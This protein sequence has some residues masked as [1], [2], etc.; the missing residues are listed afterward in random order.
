MTAEPL[1]S[2]RMGEM[3]VASGQAVLRALLG[4][5][6]GLALYDSS[7]Q[8][9]GL[10]HI[11]LPHSR[12]KTDL[13]AKFVDTAIPAMVR[14]MERVAGGPLRLQ[15]KMAGG[16]NMFA[17]RVANTIG[18]QNIEM[19]EQ[20]LKELRIPIIARHVGGEKGRNMRLES[21]TGRVFVEVVGAEMIEL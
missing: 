13:P 18:K 19:T 17:S 11:V 1:P 10:A 21:G 8:V 3:A 4:S 16:A 2:I 12:G 15:A 20:L 14:E 9:A 6:L 5:C 7:R